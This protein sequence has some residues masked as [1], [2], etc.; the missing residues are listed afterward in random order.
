MSLKNQNPAKTNAWEKLQE[1]YQK[2]RNVDMKTMFLNNNNR[3]EEYTLLFNDFTLDFSKNRINDTVLE[4]LIELANEADLKDG[5]EKMFSGD[6]I[7]TTENRAVLHTALRNKS[8][9]AVLVNDR[10]V[11]PEVESSLQKMKIFS[12]NVI[13]GKL[14]GYSGKALPILLILVLVVL[15]LDL[16]W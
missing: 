8:G 5:I 14:K 10:N 16:E 9:K 12:D 2:Y 4:Q 1:S 3:K 13:S 15:I 11:M 7:N 6:A